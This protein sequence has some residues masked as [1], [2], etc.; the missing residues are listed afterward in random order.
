MTFLTEILLMTCACMMASRYYAH[1]FQ[2]ES[3]QIDGYFRWL[4]KRPERLTGATLYFAAGAM[5]LKMLLFLLLRLASIERA[6]FFASVLVSLLL[7]AAWYRQMQKLRGESDK[8]PLVVTA[9]VKRLA[10]SLALVNLAVCALLGLLGAVSI[11]PLALGLVPITA[12]L[13]AYI[14]QPMEKAINRHY[15]MD[16]RSRLAARED[17]IKIGITGS[18]GKT[19]VKFILGTILSE[20]YNVLVPPSSYNTP[21]GLT[22]LIRDHLAPEHQVFI[23]EMGARHEGDIREL[24]QLVAPRYGIITSVGPQHLET[25]GTVE[26]VM[27]T[28]NELIE[29]LPEQG[30]AFFNADDAWVDKMYAMCAIEKQRVGIAKGTRSLWP[31]EIE[32]G[33]EGSRFVL[34]N[35]DGNRAP[36]TTRLLG[37]H[38]ISNIVLA[39]AVARRLG[40]D[41]ETIARG[42][43]KVTPVEHRLQLIRNPGGYIVIDDSFNANPH[44]A[45]A[46]LN[47]LATFQGKKFFVTPGIVEAGAREAELNRALGEQMAGVVDVA[48]LVGA[49]RA[50]ALRE[51]LDAKGFD[52]GCVFVVERPAEAS[53][54]YGRMARPGDV[55]LF[56]NDLPDTYN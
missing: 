26:R 11:M 45:K 9:R 12:A 6:E 8:K 43:A 5:A 29:A 46:A 23:A 36:M 33:P 55:I 14:A 50:A 28:K 3:Y 47:V 4:R 42:V 51:G 13:A 41:I 32:S 38:N 40:M 18:Y 54:I 52:P 31:E 48:I 21:M 44:G 17:I 37:V 2:L 1:M 27:R 10:V 34:C 25:F 49:K 22:R 30:V 39:C 16:A 35:L 53:A 56:E 20:Q 7:I 19:S 24:C 15:F